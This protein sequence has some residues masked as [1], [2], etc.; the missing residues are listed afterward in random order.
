VSKLS[1]L[2]LLAVHVHTLVRVSHKNSFHQENKN[3]VRQ[4]RL[5]TSIDKLT[6]KKYEALVK[7]H[8]F[9]MEFL[10]QYA[11][12]NGYQSNIGS[13][14]RKAAYGVVGKY[15]EKDGDIFKN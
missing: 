2:S 9:D 8:E 1:F 14:I 6:R 3:V 5:M 4:W 12:D 11:K 13:T 15:L 10:Y 7:Q